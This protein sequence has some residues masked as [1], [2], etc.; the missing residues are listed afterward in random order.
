MCGTRN[1]ASLHLLSPLRTVILSPKQEMLVYGS[2]VSTV[3]LKI[4]FVRDILLDI[5]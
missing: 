3:S 5:V 2:I 4:M 1:R